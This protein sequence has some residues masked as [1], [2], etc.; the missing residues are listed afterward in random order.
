MN[1]KSS[2][3]GKAISTRIAVLLLV[4]GAL[5]LMFSI[6]YE[7]QV[8]AFVGLGLVFW[9]ALFLHRRMAGEIPFF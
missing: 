2:G 1:P 5:S 3:D 9:G 6:L 7:S 4:P 8:P